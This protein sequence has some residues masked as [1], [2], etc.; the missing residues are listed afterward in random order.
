MVEAALRLP[1]RPSRH[2]SDQSLEAAFTSNIRRFIP[3]HWAAKNLGINLAFFWSIIAASWV[4]SVL[5]IQAVC[6]GLWCFHLWNRR[7]PSFY[8][9][10]PSNSPGAGNFIA[11]T[12]WWPSQ[13]WQGPRDPGAISAGAAGAVGAWLHVLNAQGHELHK[14]N[15]HANLQSLIMISDHHT[16][17]YQPLLTITNY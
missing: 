3:R 16:N 8:W 7:C 17:H 9:G 15:S 6:F 1:S 10:N 2:L 13:G 11:E 5:L 14:H 4:W 12:V